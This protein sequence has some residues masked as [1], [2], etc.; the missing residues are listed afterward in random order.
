MG[1]IIIQKKIQ[2]CTVEGRQ[3]ENQPK[4]VSGRRV[5]MPREAEVIGS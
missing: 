3:N 2:C 5:G 1:I 4:N